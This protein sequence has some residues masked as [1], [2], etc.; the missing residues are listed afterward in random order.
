MNNRIVHYVVFV[1]LLASTLIGWNWLW[2]LLFIFWTIPAYFSGR[3]FF[4]DMVERQK[5][6]VFYWAIL[7]TWLLLGVMMVLGDVPMLQP[8]VT[9]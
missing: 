4:I 3:V 2:G 1:L 5:E 7:L 8:Y 6:P 9:A